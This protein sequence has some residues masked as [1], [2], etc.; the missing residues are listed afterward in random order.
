MGF[1]STA[2]KMRESRKQIESESRFVWL[3]KEVNQTWQNELNQ[4]GIRE[5][6][7]IAIIAGSDKYFTQIAN[8]L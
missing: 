5:Q 8:K 2:R 1:A 7:V 6:D 3:A 4:H